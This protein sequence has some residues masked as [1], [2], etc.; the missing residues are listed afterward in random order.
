MRQAPLRS[1]LLQMVQWPAAIALTAMMLHIVANAI[2][3]LVNDR[4]LS[5]TLEITE[6]WYMPV[7]VLL[8]FVVAQLRDGH[9][10][11]ELI[12][13]FL[14]T[15]HRSV[16]VAV[17]SS[18]C[19]VVFLALAWFGLDEA[20]YATEI[21]QKG[22]GSRLPSWPVYWL[23]P[24]VFAT[25]AASFTALAVREGRRGFEPRTEGGSIHG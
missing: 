25:L 13:G 3:R 24:F 22:G 10:T 19:A 23:V 5:Y 18:I 7:L 17:G 21:D 2:L 20:R 6:F 11:V 14:T 16:V 12:D 4:P 15:R 9:I 8:G 1:A